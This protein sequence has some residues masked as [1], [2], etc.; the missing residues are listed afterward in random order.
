MKQQVAPLQATEVTSIR[1]KIATF[2][3]RINFYREVF[4]RYDFLRYSCKE[5]YVLL[6]RTDNDIKRFEKEMGD[7]QESGSL[8]E[9]SVPDFKL[10]KQCRKELKMLKVS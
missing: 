2:D 1:K 9:V 5:P 7:I 8:F 6:D 4:R 10:L 3:I